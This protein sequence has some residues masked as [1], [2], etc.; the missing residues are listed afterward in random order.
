MTTFA[1]IAI[2]IIITVIALSIVLKTAGVD[3]HLGRDGALRRVV[4]SWGGRAGHWSFVRL[5]V[6]LGKATHRGQGTRHPVV[7]VDQFRVDALGVN[8]IRGRRKR[9]RRQRRQHRQRSERRH[10]A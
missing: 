10:K 6:R 4:L 7:G 5:S 3:A 8:Y 9:R 2:I 1:V